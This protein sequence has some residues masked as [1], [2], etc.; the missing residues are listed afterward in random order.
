MQFDWEPDKAAENVG[1]HQGVTF[2]EAQAVFADPLSRTLLDPE[3][4]EGEVRYLEI[5]YSNRN[6][7]LIVC[8][9]E[10]QGRIRIINVRPLTRKERRL[11]E[12]G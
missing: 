3:H 1:K 8:Y 12:E 7:L 11:Y 5:G 6:R 9:T 10:R 4:S 2:E